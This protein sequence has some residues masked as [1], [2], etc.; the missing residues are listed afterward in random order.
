[1]AIAENSRRLIGL[2]LGAPVNSVVIV[3]SG[4]LTKTRHG[5]PTILTTGD[6]AGMLHFFSRDAASSDLV[7]A[8]DGTEIWTMS[9]EEFREL[10]KA[11]PDLIDTYIA[12]LNR[13]VR[14]GLNTISTLSQGEDTGRG[15]VAFFDTKPYMQDAFEKQNNV[16]KFGFKFSWYV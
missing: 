2:S 15:R 3:E 8:K 13:K 16:E 1:M 12:F 6:V 10:L 4:E 7:V 11:T 14:R 5:R 9:S